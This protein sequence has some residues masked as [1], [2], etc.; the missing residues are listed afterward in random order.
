MCMCQRKPQSARAAAPDQTTQGVYNSDP[1]RVLGRPRITATPTCPDVGMVMPVAT[2]V[3]PDVLK[4]VA[5]GDPAHS[6]PDPAPAPEAGPITSQAEPSYAFSSSF[7]VSYHR[8]PSLGLAGALACAGIC[9]PPTSSHSLP[10]QMLSAS[11]AVSYQPTPSLGDVGATAADV[12]PVP[13]GPRSP[14]SPL[15]PFG[16]SRTSIALRTLW[17][18]RTRIPLSAAAYIVPSAA[19]P[20]KQPVPRRVVPAIALVGSWRRSR[21]DRPA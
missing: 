10:S 21:R 20:D 7:V 18:S 6:V 19:V 17:T 13:A 3:P 11:F 15:S 5:S 14:V 4:R 2:R 12:Q 9:A 8:S 16:T 1:C